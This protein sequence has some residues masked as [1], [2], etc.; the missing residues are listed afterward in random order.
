MTTITDEM[1]EKFDIAFLESYYP[2]RHNFVASQGRQRDAIVVG[3][4]AALSALTDAGRPAPDPNAVIE[5]CAKI[6]DPWQG[7]F[8]GDPG[9]QDDPIYKVRKKIA[10]TI[11]ALKSH[12]SAES[13]VMPDQ[14]AIPGSTNNKTPPHSQPSPNADAGGASW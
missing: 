1:V 11:R 9:E 6:A 8:V 10:A 13:E 12:P 7:A 4:K 2:D 3:L 14:S 5:E